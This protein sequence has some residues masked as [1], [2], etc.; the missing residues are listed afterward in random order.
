M[1]LPEIR[2][3]VSFCL[4]SPELAN[5]VRVCKV[6]KESFTPALYYSFDA[7]NASGYVEEPT[8]FP[9]A[10]T[11]ERNSRHIRD[12]MLIQS[13]WFVNVLMTQC[14]NLRR[15]HVVLDSSAYHHERNLMRLLSNNPRLLLL[16]IDNTT[17]DHFDLTLNTAFSTCRA[18]RDV[19]LLYLHLTNPFG[20]QLEPISD[21]LRSLTLTQCQLYASFNFEPPIWP[22]FPHLSTLNLDLITDLTL[23]QQIELIQQCP[24]LVTLSWRHQDASHLEDMALALN[25]PL[26]LQGPF[27]KQA[28]WDLFRPEFCPQLRS[29]DL[30]LGTLMD[31]ILVRFLDACPVLGEIEV[32]GDSFGPLSYLPLKNNFAHLSKVNLS[33]F[34]TGMESWM[35]QEI[36][37]SCPGLESF[38][39]FKLD[40]KEFFAGPF[41][42][43]KKDKSVV[44][45]V[46]AAVVPTPRIDKDGGQIV[47]G[48]PAQ[49]AQDMETDEW[50][51]RPWCCPNLQFLTTNMA[52]DDDPEVNDRVLN[53]LYEVKNMTRINIVGERNSSRVYFNFVDNP[54]PEQL[55]R[56]KPASLWTK[57]EKEEVDLSPRIWFHPSVAWVEIST[58]DG[59]R[60]MKRVWPLLDYFCFRPMDVA[61]VLEG[62]DVDEQDDEE[63]LF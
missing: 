63:V 44:P 54:T 50:I 24:S 17:D 57:E 27:P 16:T 35:G 2:E 62:F 53:Q 22:R 43:L 39:F 23:E 1:D 25:R 6:W 49:E 10:G 20:N 32:A 21:S 26:G 46:K 5:C 45:P 18:L 8:H 31:D 40:P 42:D 48:D 51:P 41:P 28:F 33:L 61:E 30:C 36:L 14:Q 34:E 15:L 4:Q 11:L 58:N 52:C 7:D 9:S 60:W 56:A 19:A 13:H 3:L 47:E 37:T 55:A 29:I 59:L 12:L 38:V